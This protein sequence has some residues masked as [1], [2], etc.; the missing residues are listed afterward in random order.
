VAVLYSALNA[1]MLWVR[2]RAENAA[3]S[4]VVA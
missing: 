3:Y 1:A 4:D 2:I